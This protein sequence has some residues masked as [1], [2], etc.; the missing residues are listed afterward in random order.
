MRCWLYVLFLLNVVIFAYF[1]G[2]AWLATLTPKAP[3]LHPENIRLI[4]PTQLARLEAMTPS[5]HNCYVWGVFH[6]AQTATVQSV[7][8][9]LGFNGKW[10][11]YNGVAFELRLENISLQ[12]LNLLKH[13]IANF[14]AT[15]LAPCQS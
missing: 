10:I 1:Q 12:N 9:S 14:P 13:Y 8:V 7:L 6:S 3:A 15:Q 5:T 11:S 2:N 4:L